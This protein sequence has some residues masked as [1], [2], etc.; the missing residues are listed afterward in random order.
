[1]RTLRIGT[2]RSALAL[3]QA[4]EV[5]AALAKAG[6]DAELV[7]LTTTGDEGVPATMPADSLKGLW[8]DAILEALRD[9]T[10]DLAVHSAKD[11]PA[12]DDDELPIA[13]VPLRA[14]PRD[15]LI[16]REPGARLAPGMVVGTSSIRRRAQILNRNPGVTVAAL[17]GNVDT[18]LRKLAEGEVDAAVLA[19]AGLERLGLAPEGAKPIPVGAM[20]PAP[21]QGALAVQTRADARDVRAAVSALDHRPSRLSLASERALTRALDGGCSLPLGALAALKGDTIRLAG[22]VITPLGDRTLDAAAEA[23]DPGVVATMVAAQLRQAGADQILAEA[24]SA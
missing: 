9:G 16:T 7:P 15:V 11:L 8:I 22:R 19:A 14:D 18:R 24:R 23:A 21:G 5:R 17:R 20:L 2:R 13:A 3:A 10:I 4:E 12:E 1:V 6:T